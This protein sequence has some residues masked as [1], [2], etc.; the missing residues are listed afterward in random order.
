MINLKC[1]GLLVATTLSAQVRLQ[2][3]DLGP[4]PAPCCMV[5]D[6]SGNVYVAG[7]YTTGSTNGVVSSQKIIVSKLSPANNLVYRVI[8]GGSVIDTPIAI[9]ADSN[10]NLFVVGS[11][12]S[13]D[14]PLVTPLIT[15]GPPAN[16]GPPEEPLAQGFLS[17]IGPTGNL[18]F[19]TFIGGAQSNAQT[20]VD[21]IA[22]DTAENVYLT[23]STGAADFPVTP[24]AFN[25]T[26]NA[27]V[28]KITHA[29]N[30][31]SFSTF[32][33]SYG[34]GLALAVD[35]QGAITV[36]GSVSTEG[37]FP[38]TAGAFQTMCN[39]GRAPGDPLALEASY[40]ASFVLRLSADG[41]RLLWSTYLSGGGRGFPDVAFADTVQALALTSDGGVVVAGT[42]ETPEFPTTPGAFQTTLR[43]QNSPLGSLFPAANLFV[44]RLNSTGTALTFS[45]FLGGSVGEVLTGLQLD[46]QEHAWVTGTTASPDFPVLAHGVAV[47]NEFVVE[48]S[49]DGSSLLNTQMFPYGSAGIAVALGASGGE[50]LLGESGSLIRIPTGALPGISILAQVN[51]AAYS[52]SGKLSPGEIFSL[53]GTGLGPVS[54]V[55]GQFDATG[56]LPTKLAGVQVTCGGAP[57]PLLYVSAHQI[58]AVVPFEASGKQSIAVQV[59]SPSGS[60]TPLELTEVPAYPEVFSLPTGALPQ[61]F[62]PYQFFYPYAVALNEDGTLNSTNNPAKLGST[63]L[64]WVNGAG[65][66]TSTLHDGTTAQPP[67]PEP[68]LPVS[69]LFGGQ[70]IPATYSAAPD[71]VAGVLQVSTTLPQVIP[72]T[73]SG[74]QVQVG[75]FVSDGVV[76]A[77]QP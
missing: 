4:Q 31:I 19:S 65:L 77:V 6:A 35:S 62:H 37:G 22:L 34:T 27:F 32:I 51:A 57:A 44:T 2:Y 15:N 33:G 58:N 64:F 52:P 46:P 63:V 13:P 25:S 10:G 26:G 40:S 55:S 9:A 71:L 12:N 43:A 60:T 41:S 49:P 76:I 24:D 73:G 54:G 59:I 8:F 14:F 16:G 1:L 69:V 30:Q 3:L 7:S 53:Y 61:V 36:G 72:A 20:V 42:A 50:T 38:A 48:L 47:G 18:A 11:T 21:A 74:L 75:D 23:G 5:T 17:K 68:D 28:M 45:T 29:G 56:K 67:L 70:P 39:C 66:F